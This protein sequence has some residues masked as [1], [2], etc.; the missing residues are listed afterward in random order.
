MEARMPEE[1]LNEVKPWLPPEKRP[2]P[3]GGRPSIGHGI[4]LKVIWF[5]LVT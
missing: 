1:F 3:Q 2:G 4:D 5:V